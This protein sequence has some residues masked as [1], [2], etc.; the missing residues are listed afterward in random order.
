[1]PRLWVLQVILTT[2]W[3][4]AC[5]SSSPL[6]SSSSPIINGS[7]DLSIEAIGALTAE[8]EGSQQAFCTGTLITSRL[9]LTAAHCVAAMTGE[10][11]ALY[12]F[13]VDKALEG[14]G[15]QST[16]YAIEEV[17]AHPRYASSL[18]DRAGYDVAVLILKDE[19]KDVL[20]LNLSLGGIEK[21]PLGGLLRYAGYGFTKTQPDIVFADQK[22]SA[23]IP[24]FQLF[25]RTF[26]TWDREGKKSACHGDSGGPALL[27]VGGVWEIVG[28][29]SQAYQATV[30]Q[31]QRYTN[32]D[33][34]VLSTRVDANLAF[35][36][37]FWIS[38]H[39]PPRAC[40]YDGTCTSCG[41]CEQFS[42]APRGPQDMDGLC[43]PCQKDGD[44]CGEGGR[45]FRREEGWRCLM[46]CGEAS[47]FQ[48]P[49]GYQ[50]Q[51]I[52]G[53]GVSAQFY[54]LP[55]QGACAEVACQE[56]GQCGYAEIC[57]GGRCRLRRPARSPS[58][59]QTCYSS[60]SC[61]FDGFCNDNHI[62]GYCTQPCDS[63]RLCPEGFRCEPASAGFNQCVP[64]RS[65][66]I[67][68]APNLPCP[69]GM[70]CRDGICL[71][72]GGGQ[73]GDFCDNVRP[74]QAGFACVPSPTNPAQS[75]CILRCDP[76][77]GQSGGACK[78][79]NTCDDGLLC[80]QEQAPT[81]FPSCSG[82]CEKGGVCEKILDKHNI[83]LCHAHE[84]CGKDQFC[85]FGRWGD[86]GVG[87]CTPL[88]QRPACPPGRYC[89]ARPPYGMLCLGTK[90]GYQEI[91]S[92]CD[93]LQGCTDRGICFRMSSIQSQ[94]R[95]FE[96][97]ADKKC[98]AGGVCRNL[99]A[100]WDICLCKDHTECQVNQ[101]CELVISGEEDLGICVPT[102]SSPCFRDDDCPREFRCGAG[103]CVLDVE[104]L[105]EKPAP[106]GGVVDL[107][108]DAGPKEA[109]GDGVSDDAP[110]AGGG[111]DWGEGAFGERGGW[112]IL[113]FFLWAMGRRFRS[114]RA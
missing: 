111:C 7:P 30:H 53:Y 96:Q 60:A 51:N 103:H 10:R 56:D 101:R 36:G 81:C 91:G 75:R 79:G 37:R 97:C 68:C 61:G 113:L 54:C 33:G 44:P 6:S 86:V 49:D 90:P 29:T 15:F 102:L 69:D 35:L 55:N 40:L 93:D 43:L 82:S 25:S 87:A 85:N 46:P 19:V 105:L 39:N 21:L 45:C 41:R 99:G 9:V 58:L 13:R 67:A 11:L 106:D 95:C 98:L 24:L 18:G 5:Q 65:C 74:C 3:L 72:G 12:R 89:R 22:Y 38:Y 63:F 70:A 32:C 62:M 27:Q 80:L 16:Y 4:G 104:R 109:L 83:C 66:D 23:D 78:A 84:D 64:K 92:P 76:P 47:C 42:C 26:V 57:D 31:N 59:C 14:G 1:M 73:D 112:G 28:V 108:G 52:E 110:K 17:H 34:G 48:C 71:R 8:Q 94:A 114:L 100:G 50:C 107:T 20:P 2:F 77:A 88:S